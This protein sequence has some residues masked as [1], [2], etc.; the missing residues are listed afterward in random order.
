MSGR[1]SGAKKPVE[2]TRPDGTTAQYES[3]SA[4]SRAEHITQSDISAM[5]RGTMT[6]AK[7]KK[8]RFIDTFTPSPPEPRVD[9]A[10]L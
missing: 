5:C 8:A 6:A 10:S 7:G 4:A 9:D 1:Y 3:G 2:I